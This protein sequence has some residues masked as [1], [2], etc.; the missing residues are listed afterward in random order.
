MSF[1]EINRVSN[2]S[3][4]SVRSKTD[5]HAGD[6]IDNVPEYKRGDVESL[7]LEKKV[8]ITDP[9]FGPSI[10]KCDDWNALL[11]WLFPFVGEI[12]EDGPNYRNVH[13]HCRATNRACQLSLILT[14]HRWD[15]RK[16]LYS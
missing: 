16:P 10:P 15:G 4:H 9:V 6:Q 1:N 3:L 8:T 5:E 12:T 2:G 7:Q 13:H 14:P 11:T